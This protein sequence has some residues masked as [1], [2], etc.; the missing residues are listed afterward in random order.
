[1]SQINKGLDGALQRFATRALEEAYPYLI[2]DA[3]Y[4]KVRIDGVIR[5]QAVLIAIGINW[6]GRRQ[7]LGVELADREALTSWKDFVRRLRQRGLHG[8]EFT[9]SDDHVGLNNG[10]AELLPE[11]AWQGCYVHFLWNALV[12]L[13]RKADAYCLQE[14]R[15]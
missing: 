14:L 15:W 5:S 3:R 10:L 7:V 2:L 4:E 12:Y 9:V 6:E 11:A 13:P 8:G 1:I